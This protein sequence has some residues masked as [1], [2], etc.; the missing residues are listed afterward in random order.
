MTKI[1]PSDVASR[2]DVLDIINRPYTEGYS[3]QILDIV[4][5][6][7]KGEVH[8][9]GKVYAFTPVFHVTAHVSASYTTD[10]LTGIN[11]NTSLGSAVA[12]LTASQRIPRNDLAEDHSALACQYVNP[13]CHHAHLGL[14]VGSFRS[15]TLL[16]TTSNSRSFFAQTTLAVPAHSIPTRH[17]SGGLQGRS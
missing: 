8:H 12:R 3:N 7:A 16:S 10:G 2:Q 1:F 15:T 9:A 14:L 17:A 11:G 4:V 13:F 5:D 6:K